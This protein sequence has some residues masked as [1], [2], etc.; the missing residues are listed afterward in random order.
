[1]NPRPTNMLV[2]D[3]DCELCRWAQGLLV[4][5]DRHRRITYLA[6]QDPPFREWFPELNRSDPTGLWPHGE[7]PRAMLYIDDGG[8]LQIG[9]DAF[10]SM[11]PRLS[12]GRALA[13]LFY[14]PGVPWLAA[15]FYDWLARNRYRL[16]G[17]TP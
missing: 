1:L 16:F 7:P 13:L 15:R 5:W 11:L 10:R 2:Y 12:G 17:P 6:F 3:R 8:R 9:M 14:L 4:R